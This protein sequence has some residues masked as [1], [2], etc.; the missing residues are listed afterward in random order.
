MAKK[1]SNLELAVTAARKAFGTKK[2]HDPKDEDTVVPAEDTFIDGSHVTMVRVN[3]NVDKAAF[4][5]SDLDP[6]KDDD[7]G[8]L[9]SPVIAEAEHLVLVDARELLKV[10]TYITSIDKYPVVELKIKGTDVPLII[11]YGSDGRKL[12]FVIS[13]RVESNK[14]EEEDEDE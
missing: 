3:K 4:M 8:M 1:K 14:D 5:T 11:E 2:T 9:N 10:A 7:V 13:P 6:F 12:T